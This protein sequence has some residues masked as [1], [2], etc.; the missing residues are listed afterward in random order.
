MCIEKMKMY[1]VVRY[2][3]IRCLVKCLPCI[4]RTNSTTISILTSFQ[5]IWY[6]CFFVFCRV[7]SSCRFH[8]EPT[9]VSML[10]VVSSLVTRAEIWRWDLN[11]RHI[12]T[13]LVS[14]QN[15]IPIP[16]VKETLRSSP[17]V[18]VCNLL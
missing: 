13:F 7:R 8:K 18:S 6:I 5:F 16:F 14:L 2:P 17:P 15:V 10:A 12:H 11:P 1:N 3:Q 4:F 9:L